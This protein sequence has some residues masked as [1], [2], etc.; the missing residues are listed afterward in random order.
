MWGKG[1]PRPAGTSLTS[2]AR[3]VGEGVRLDRGVGQVDAV[4]GAATVGVLIAVRVLVAGRA[5]A[6]AFGVGGRRLAATVA[7]SHQQ[8][9]RDRGTLRHVRHS[10]LEDTQFS[11]LPRPHGRSQIKEL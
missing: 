3:L 11:N 6:R 4:R 10:Q 1:P 9:G 5:G 8:Q 7:L 2:P